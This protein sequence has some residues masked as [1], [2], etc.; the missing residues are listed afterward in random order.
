MYSE[1]QQKNLKK[2]QQYIE[3][4]HLVSQELLKDLAQKNNWPL[5]QS[6][7]DGSVMILSGLTESG[8]PLYDAT[9]TNSGAALTTQT[10]ALYEGGGLDLNLN[11]GSAIIKD[12][13]GIWDGGK[14]LNT[15]SE[16][17]GRI[18]QV[19]NAQ[20]TDTHATHV[21][22]TMI[23]AGNNPR[24]KGMSNGANLQAHD[25]S[26]DSPEM[27]NAAANLL[28]SNHSYGT[29]T[30]WRFNADRPGTDN[31]LKWEW[32][33]DTTISAQKD[34]KF[35]FYDTRAREWDRI[36]YNAPNYLIVKSAG[37]DR[38]SNG[39]PAGTPY[40]FGSSNRTSTTPRAAQNDYDLISTYGTAKNILTV[41][42]VSVLTNGYNQLSDPRI[43]SFSGWGPTDDGRIKPDI[44]GV[45]VSVFSL[46]S[47]S[48]NA[49]TTL[50]GTSMA[51]PNV[52]GSL[53]L[54][55]ELYQKQTT[56]FM[57]SS[58][59]KGLILHTAN[60]A[61]NPGPDYQYGWGL[62]STKKAAEVIL[63]RD[64]T[65]QISERTLS[66]NE[67][68]TTQVVASGKGSLIVTICWTD[69]EAAASSVTVANFDNR[70]P[71]LLNDLDVR[72]SDGTTEFLPWILDPNQPAKNATQGD[73]IRDNVEQ[74]LLS[75][76]V[77][78]RIYTITIKHKGTLTNGTQ[79]YAL[80]ISGIGG[81]AYCD[82][83]A[84]SNTDTKITQVVVGGITQTA[85]EGCQTYS[86]F[87]TRVANISAG[88]SLPLEVTVG[89]CGTPFAKVVKTFIDWNNDGDFD[90]ANESIGTSE[91]ISA[92]GTFRTNIIAPSG[93]SVDNLTRLRIVCVETSNPTTITACGSYTKGETQEFLLRIT[94]PI[95]DISLVA[96]VAPD[97]NF[98]GGQ[99]T[100]LT[101]RVRNVGTTAQQNIPVVVDI[102]PAASGPKIATLRGTIAQSLAAFTETTLTLSDPLLAALQAGQS[103]QFVCRTLLETDQDTLNNVLLQTRTVAVSPTITSATA[104]YCGTDPA[105]LIARSNNATSNAFGTIA[106]P[107]KSPLP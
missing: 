84:T 44:V 38:G 26:N 25:F 21:S 56:F 13:L 60:D 63:N 94:R 92:I 73:N 19:D 100:N 55:Q 102:L 47:T 96:L 103:Y 41:G 50:S 71:K 101:V 80:I 48:D 10:N 42:A 99:L 74:I 11:G 66:P 61:G 72:V 104:T 95:N 58:T 69:P 18:T 88:Q 43:S 65:H 3:N 34:Y 6:F 51:T 16:L 28:I 23:A 86:D 106:Q 75:N 64:K 82:S 70:T 52:S 59:L 49:Y 7:G 22:G 62:L 9:H 90:D 105:A 36:A 29:V 12:R 83:R 33:G 53:F 67:T 14:V 35:G 85:K 2:V 81:N 30:G 68:Y 37:N 17:Q 97:N 76:P 5:R 45:G 89:S 87:M 40:F 57:R 20:T 8:Q 24:A 4:Q 1:G 91:V 46:S 54:L 77:P 98:C 78:G 32:Y 27:A 39:P 107:P 15:H 79:P 31:N 93:L